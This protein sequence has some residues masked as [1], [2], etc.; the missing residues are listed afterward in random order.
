MPLRLAPGLRAPLVPVAALGH[1]HR[2]QDL[3]ELILVP[4][5]RRHRR[6]L[7][8]GR[9]PRVG[10]RVFFYYLEGRLANVQLQLH[11]PGLRLRLAQHVPRHLDVIGQVVEPLAHGLSLPLGF[12]AII[13]HHLPAPEV[14]CRSRHAVSLG[15]LRGGPVPRPGP[16]DD[17]HLPLEGNRLPPGPR[18]SVPS[19]SRR[20]LVDPLAELLAALGVAKG[21]RR[22]CQALAVLEVVLDG[23]PPRLGG[24]LRVRGK[25]ACGHL[26]GPLVL[27][28]PCS[29]RGPRRVPELGDGISIAM[30]E[31]DEGPCRE[32]SPLL[33]VHV[34]FL[35]VPSRSKI[36]TAVPDDPRFLLIHSGGAERY[37]LHVIATQRE[38]PD[39]ERIPS[40]YRHQAEDF[41][42]WFKV[43]KIERAERDVMAKCVVKSS[44]K[45]LTLASRHSMSPHFI[46]EYNPS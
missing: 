8:V 6:L 16:G 12:P 43:A 10:A 32:P 19:P 11:P 40:Y 14:G 22:P 13:A 44:G 27:V 2:R 41:G 28:P 5:R 46:I 25:P 34:V 9:R 26:A 31:F 20:E 30:V 45:S 23:S 3:A 37:W 21:P 7:R 38:T 1:A 4:R 39:L 35:P 33:A 17:P 18:T 42:C 24:V 29:Q 36:P 15:Y